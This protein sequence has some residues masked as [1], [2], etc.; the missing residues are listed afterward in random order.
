[1]AGSDSGVSFDSLDVTSFEVSPGASLGDA[2]VMVFVGTGH[3][4]PVALSLGAEALFGLASAAVGACERVDRDRMAGILR[5]I[6]VRFR[7]SGDLDRGAPEPP[8]GS[9][10]AATTGFTAAC[11]S[12]VDC[13]GAFQA[14]CRG[15]GLGDGVIAALVDV[16][17]RTGALG[18]GNETGESLIESPWVEPRVDRAGEHV[19]P[20]AGAPE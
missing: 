17:L 13:V 6:V 7:G 20:A 2:T 15:R 18:V 8:T 19:D 11:A 9:P 12:L 1:M 3:P 5:A 16:G 14:H 4:R 10:P